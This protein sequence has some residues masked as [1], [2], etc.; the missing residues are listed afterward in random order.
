M[1]QNVIFLDRDGVLTKEKSYVCKREELEILPYAKEAV[2]ILKELGY[3]IIVVTNQSAV[4]RGILL[5]EE[6]L[7]MNRMLEDELSV[8]HVYYCPHLPPSDEEEPSL[9]RISCTCRKPKTGMLEQAFRDYPL[10]KEASYFVGDRGSDIVVGQAFGVHSVL[11]N[12]G[13]GAKSLEAHIQ[14]DY[15]FETVLEFAQYLEKESKHA[16]STV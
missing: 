5:E 3:C 14:P 1:K 6:L 15:I 8:D 16:I 2:R 10:T 12:S 4:A 9:Y 11:V 13:Y 7:V